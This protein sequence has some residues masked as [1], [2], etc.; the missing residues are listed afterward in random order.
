MYVQQRRCLAA[1]AQE[2][3]GTNCCAAKWCTNCAAETAGKL[4]VHFISARGKLC[5]LNPLQGPWRSRNSALT[6]N[7]TSD[8]Q[9]WARASWVVVFLATRC[10]FLV[11]H[12]AELKSG[13][14]ETEKSLILITT[15]LRN[16][17]LTF[18]LTEF[19]GNNVSVY[20]HPSAALVVCSPAFLRYFPWLTP[21][22]FSV[23][24]RFKRAT[25][26]I[27]RKQQAYVSHRATLVSPSP[28]LVTPE[29]LI[30]PFDQPVRRGL[31]QQI[32]QERFKNTQQNKR[33]GEGW[34]GDPNRPVPAIKENEITRQSLAINNNLDV[35]CA[36]PHSLER[37]LRR[38]PARA[39]WLHSS[40]PWLR[41][42][43]KCP[44]MALCWFSPVRESLVLLRSEVLLNL[45]TQ[46]EHSTGRK[47]AAILSG[48][49]VWP[50][51]LG[52]QTALWPGCRLPLRPLLVGPGQGSGGEAGG[53]LLMAFTLFALHSN[54]I[55]SR[56]R[57]SGS[58]F[59]A[60]GLSPG[61]KGWGREGRE[62]PPGGDGAA[63]NCFWTVTGRK[64]SAGANC[65]SHRGE[66]PALG[67]ISVTIRRHYWELCAI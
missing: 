64:E 15:T 13:I 54:R 35:Y 27:W 56:L 21:I 24:L 19:I 46:A 16:Y 52:N 45:L 5:G 22:L 11:W 63:Q 6:K 55:F 49:I 59:P 9:L 14:G 17:Y 39:G 33:Q 43:W 31:N 8:W 40:V 26:W 51:G 67:N 38:P 29:Y 7:G 18:L 25:P 20:T 66:L 42:S 4:N 47:E 30:A 3:R 60:L 23:S 65:R 50:P 12:S 58:R 32:R 41:C 48:P 53:C 36:W 10:A 1:D 34:A 28:S 37:R 44:R 2:S 57:A 61:E 62:S